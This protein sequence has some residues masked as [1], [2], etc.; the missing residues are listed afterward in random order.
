MT[1]VCSVVAVWGGDTSQRIH[2]WRC[3]PVHPVEAT[4]G[5]AGP[6]VS[7]NARRLATAHV[8]MPLVLARRCQRIR[9]CLVSAHDQ[10]P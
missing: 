1:N 2:G 5:D 9:L 3:D 6:M 4:G 10:C 7:K 8:T